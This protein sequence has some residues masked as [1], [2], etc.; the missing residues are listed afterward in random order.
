MTF[1]NY[2]KRSIYFKIVKNKGKDEL[3]ISSENSDGLYYFTDKKTTME[4]I[5]QFNPE[6][7]NRLI[8]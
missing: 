8:I 7:L 1:K 2:L 4:E 6:K 5:R 3:W